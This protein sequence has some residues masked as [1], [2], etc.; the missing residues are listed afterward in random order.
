MYRQVR[1]QEE[2]QNK[3]KQELIQDLKKCQQ[4]IN[5]LQERNED[6]Q[7]NETILSE[8]EALTHTGGWEWDIENNKLIVSNEWRAIHGCKD[9]SKRNVI[10]IDHLATIAH[11]DDLP[12][13]KKAQKDALEGIK[14][15]DIEHRIIRQNDGEV[16][17]LKVM[18]KVERD[19]NGKPVKMYGVAQDITEYKE[20]KEKLQRTID[21]YYNL[22]D[23]MND[24]VFV[25][26]LDGY[27]LDVNKHAVDVLGYTKEELINKHVAE[28]SDIEDEKSTIDK[29]SH[30]NNNKQ[31]KFESVK[32][33][34]NDEKVP[35]EVNSTLVLYRGNPAI[36]SIARNITERK[37]A[38][39][40]INKYA[41]QLK[42]IND[43]LETRVSEQTEQIRK[44]E[45]IR[46][47]ELH[48]RIKNNL[49]IINSLINLQFENFDDEDVINAFRDTQNR[50]AS[51]SL[52]HQKLY[53]SQELNNLSLND[54]IKDL[55]ENLNDLYSN[56][57]TKI[58][59]DVQDFHLGIDTIIPLGMIVN[60]IVSNSLKYAFSD[61]NG[62]INIKFYSNNCYVLIIEDN[63]K[64]IPDN[65]DIENPDTLGLQ[66]INT[67]IKQLNGEI[68]LDRKNGTKFIIRF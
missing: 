61:D 19:D 9:N 7:K 49:Q 60:E 41:E 56:S 46:E 3:S 11:P 45:R 63:G 38:E 48:H 18:G 57:N 6:L 54:Y 21:E 33:T 51:M 44:N 50:V 53:Q 24:A 13:I 22:F 15:Y 36:L 39:E 55:A 32:L 14:P 64:G 5:Y 16:K 8:A 10:S 66:L 31:L 23:S 42:N 68:V 62:I 2:Y 58:N 12:F 1:M 52:V 47:L 37:K 65:I 25:H 17:H 28:L 40:E 30:I 4:Q 67:L 27:L 20:L 59:V 26:D 34:K 35:F 43:E 29:I